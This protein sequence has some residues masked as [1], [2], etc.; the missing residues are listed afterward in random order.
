MDIITGFENKIFSV[1]NKCPSDT[2]FL[3]AVSGGAD[4]MAMLTAL[5]SISGSRLPT[6][7]S[8]LCVLHVEHGLRP[9]AESRGDAEFVR[10]FC[11]ERKIECHV[12][13]IPPGKIAAYAKR[14][15]IGIEA[16][17]RFFRHRALRAEV[18]RICDAARIGG[19]N[20]RILTA[21]TRDDLLE[22]SLMRVLR[23]CGPAG[24]AAMAEG[25]EQRTANKVQLTEN[26]EQLSE[27]KAKI[28]RPLLSFC[29]ADVIA[30]LNTKGIS[31]REDA[32]NKDEKF[33]RN[34]IRRRLVPLLDEAFPSW[35]EG[36]AAM[37]ETQ[38]LAAEFIADEARR[39]VVWDAG[40]RESGVGNRD[41]YS[42]N[43]TGNNKQNFQ[44]S[45]PTPHSLL[46][47]PYLSTDDKNFFLQPLIVREEAIFQAVD[48]LLIKAKNPR[49]VKRAV[50]RRFCLSAETDAGVKAADFGAVTVRRGDGKVLLSRKR[51]EFFERGVSVL[52]K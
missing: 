13:H 35:K 4:S 40:S 46:P 16:A 18:A 21:H 33:L 32:T 43:Y 45:I 47:T 28:V 30:Y 37:A 19:A 36:I 27:N 29:R 22:T 31:W 49:S 44:T 50:V 48:V 26:R 34:R 6:P 2:V 41:C 52:V 17:A 1:L 7:R 39:R 3:A 8:P 15:G 25:R 42:K 14:K 9:E 20:I 10:K 12:K 11:E 5:F 24:L 38:S 51:K 23:G